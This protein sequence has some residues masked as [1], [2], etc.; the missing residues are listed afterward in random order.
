MSVYLYLSAAVAVIAAIA[1]SYIGEVILFRPLFAETAHVGVMKS[2]TLRRVS[3]AVWHLPSVS[4]L[5]MSAMT[6]VLSQQ[7]PLPPT[8]LYFAAA[9]YFLSGAGN[10]IAT[11]G[12]HFGWVVL[13]IAAILLCVGI[14][15]S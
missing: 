13:W 7:R 12:R 6:L 14:P 3:R 8:P 4:W 1:H 2:L 10:L 9:V 11:R 15:N 5:L